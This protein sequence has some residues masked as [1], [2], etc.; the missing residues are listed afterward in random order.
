MKTLTN[1]IVVSRALT[2]STASHKQSRCKQT[3]GIVCAA[4]MLTYAN[5]AAAIPVNINQADADVIA[6]ALNGIGEKTA[7]K[8]VEYRNSNG[9]YT[10][11]DDLLNISGIGE[12]KLAK[13]K[14]DVKLK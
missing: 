7:I 10:S 9:L 5:L 2:Q 14:D 12:K 3:L 6:D 8:I 13:I 1:N 11:A 4:F